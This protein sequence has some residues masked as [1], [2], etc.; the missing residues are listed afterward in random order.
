MKNTILCVCLLA[1]LGSSLSCNVDFTDPVDE[2]QVWMVKGVVAT[3]ADDLKLNNVRVNAYEC[4]FC[5][6]DLDCDPAHYAAVM[7]DKDG[8]FNIAYYGPGDCEVYINRDDIHPY[9]HYS[10]NGDSLLRHCQYLDKT[11]FLDIKVW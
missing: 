10:I 8:K 4:M 6:T 2:K 9:Q 1:V 3:R 5:L 7:T 11:S